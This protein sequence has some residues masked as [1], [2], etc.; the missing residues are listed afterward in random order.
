MGIL[1]GGKMKPDLLCVWPIHLDYPLYRKFLHDNR[2][3]FAKVIVVFTQMNTGKDYS[4]WV[5]QELN[6]DGVIS[7][8]NDEVLSGDWRNVA[9]RKGLSYSDA[10]WVFFT[11]EDFIPDPNFWGEFEIAMQTKSIDVIGVKQDTRLHPCCIFIK[12]SVLDKTSKDF[13]AHPP[14]HDHFGQIQKDLMNFDPPLTAFTIN[15]KLYTH[16]N[17]LSQ[18]LYLLM[19]GEQPNYEPEK[20]RKYCQKCLQLD[21]PIQPDIKKLMED[22]IK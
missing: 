9:V 15:P 4:E 17:G 16:M 5:R 8:Y 14:E 11:E 18:N 7:I 20:F 3:R 21:L 1:G 12:R 19:V 10:E 2:E 13:S 22:Y 6:K